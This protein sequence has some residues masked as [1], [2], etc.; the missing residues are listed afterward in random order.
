M[1]GYPTKCG[2]LMFGHQNAGM[3]DLLRQ[4]AG[5]TIDE[6]TDERESLF[7]GEEQDEI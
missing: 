2:R 1:G 6:E 4:S 3:R 7:S 5:V